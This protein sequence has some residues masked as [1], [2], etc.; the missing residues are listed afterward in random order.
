MRIDAV[1][2][3]ID[4]LQLRSVTPRTQGTT[5][6]VPSLQPARVEAAPTLAPTGP[7]RVDLSA[8]LFTRNSRSGQIAATS[9]R[10]SADDPSLVDQLRRQRLALGR[11]LSG[12]NRQID[13]LSG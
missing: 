8:D 7:V 11:L 4:R 3:P 1:G 10:Q 2:L 5:F 9:R 13:G 6:S 12:V